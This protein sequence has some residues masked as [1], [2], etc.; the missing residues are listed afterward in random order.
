MSLEILI[1]KKSYIVI[2]FHLWQSIRIQI[3]RLISYSI[4]LGI[5]KMEKILGM[6]PGVLTIPFFILSILVAIF[7][8]DTV[9]YALGIYLNL[10][11]P[12]LETFWGYIIVLILFS[13]PLLNVGLICLLILQS[14]AVLLKFIFGS[15]D[16]S[17]HGFVTM[18]PA[19]MAT[20]ALLLNLLSRD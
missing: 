16:P 5:F 11:F 18:F 20:I 12:V 3:I 1:L 10:W 14:F 2:Q 8:P 7:L 9:Y 15:Y 4:Y 13:I 19:C 17:L 6:I